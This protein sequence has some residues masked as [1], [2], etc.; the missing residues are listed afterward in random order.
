MTFFGGWLGTSDDDV[1]EFLEMLAKHFGSEGAAEAWLK[2][3]NQFFDM[4]TPLSM[5]PREVAKLREFILS[6]AD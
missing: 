2:A 6:G 5:L 4:R 1:K 3:P